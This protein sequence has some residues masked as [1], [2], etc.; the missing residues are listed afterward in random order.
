MRPRHCTY[1]CVPMRSSSISKQGEARFKHTRCL[2]PFF[3][4]T[5][6]HPLYVQ[7]QVLCEVLQREWAVVF[8]WSETQGSHMTLVHRDREYFGLLWRVSM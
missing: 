1:V 2:P 5:T 4:C 6:K 7:V 8:Y 3:C